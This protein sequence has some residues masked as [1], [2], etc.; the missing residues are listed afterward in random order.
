M[1]KHQDLQMFGHKIGCGSET[2][3]LSGEKLNYV[4]VCGLS[5]NFLLF[6]LEKLGFIFT[7]LME[8]EKV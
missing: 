6:S 7:F 2:Q 5:L 8:R 4:M 1:F 3:L